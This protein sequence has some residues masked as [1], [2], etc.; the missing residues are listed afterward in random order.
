M[1][2]PTD[3][4]EWCESREMRTRPH[5][6]EAAHS[7]TWMAETCARATGQ[8]GF[9]SRASAG[10]V[11]CDAYGGSGHRV[12]RGSISR[13][14]TFE[15]NASGTLFRDSMRC[16]GGTDISKLLGSTR[17]CTAYHAAGGP[18]LAPL[19]QTHS[20]RRP[21]HERARSRVPPTLDSTVS[22]SGIYALL[23]GWI[24]LISTS[25]WLHR[26]RV[27]SLRDEAL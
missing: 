25:Y 5:S 6:G 21:A 4:K 16:P 8:L 22:I 24:H 2:V 1:G 12:W 17:P 23:V 3:G 14:F 20:E 26:P 10:V 27:R 13:T 15:R 19:V 9:P 11:R 7:V 18:T